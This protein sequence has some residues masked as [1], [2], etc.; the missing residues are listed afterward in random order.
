M[1]SKHTPGPWW[2]E[3]NIKGAPNSVCTDDEDGGAR[4][5]A[6]IPSGAQ[7]NARDN[8]ALIAAAP[9]LLDALRVMVWRYEDT[10]AMDDEDYPELAAARA[11]LAK[12]E[13]R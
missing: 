7:D 3:H 12:A 4:T 10:E 5:I 9:E 8:A 2:R 1:E 11:A 13:G 6:S